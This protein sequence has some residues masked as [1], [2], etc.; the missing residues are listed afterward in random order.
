MASGRS[1]KP[2]EGVRRR[3][4]ILARAYITG[5]HGLEIRMPDYEK[6]ADHASEGKRNPSLPLI[7]GILSSFFLMI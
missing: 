6:T 2:R 1:Q 3:E 7:K 4:P 5:I